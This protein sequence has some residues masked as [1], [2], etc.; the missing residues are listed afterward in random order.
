MVVFANPP[1]TKTKKFRGRSRATETV[2]V[3]LA[4]I[5]RIVREMHASFYEYSRPV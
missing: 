4:A 2:S 3:R 5:A 1:G